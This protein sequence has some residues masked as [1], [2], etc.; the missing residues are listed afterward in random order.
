METNIPMENGEQSDKTKIALIGKDIG[1]IN[2][3]IK[4]IKQSIQ[5][6]GVTFVTTMQYQDDKRALE[7]RMD[8]LE[9]SSNL[10]RWLSPTLA[11]VL[12][13]VLT[14]LIVSYFQNLK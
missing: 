13:S 5:G 2:E 6:F 4:E 10:W 12:G 14:F 8:R 1:Y 9:K 3:N 11:A 7:T